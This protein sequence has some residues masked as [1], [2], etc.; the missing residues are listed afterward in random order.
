MNVIAYYLGQ[1][2]PII[3]NDNYWGEGFTEWHN[4]ARARPLYP[5]HNQPMLPGR[6]GFY[7]LRADSVIQAQARL[8]KEIGVDTFCYWHYWFAGKRVLYKPLDRI[9]ALPR[10]GI[11]VMLGWANES[12]T[13]IWHGLSNKILLEQTYNRQELK[14]HAKLIASYLKSDRYL[15]LGESSPFLIY[16]PRLIPSCRSYLDELRDCV[17][18]FGGGELYIIG[19]WGP[20]DAE[21]INRPRDIGLDA[22]VATPV[23]KYFNNRYVRMTYLAAW[24]IAKRL[25]IGPE[26]RRF[27]SI[28]D[29]L[30]AAYNL[31]DGT[32]HSTIV[33]GWDNTPRSRRGGLVLAG[34][35]KKSLRELAVY[36]LAKEQQNTQNNLIFIKSWNEWAEGNVLEAKFNEKWSAAEV[37]KDV[38]SG[39]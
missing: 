12:W 6:F 35:S 32:I 38:F 7:D 10:P 13:G 2:H 14:Q 27:G 34:Y 28:K 19:N 31:V 20:G 9:M 16:K 30:K 8:A 33:T 4:V 18:K 5:G 24:K 29:T 25:G 3:E 23:G 36:A 21:Q 26:I 11:K 22:V 37:L 39:Q 15:K 1:Y 17:R